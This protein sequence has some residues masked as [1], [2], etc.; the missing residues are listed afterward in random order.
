MHGWL[1]QP[2][3]STAGQAS[4][5]T[6]H[7]DLTALVARRNHDTGPYH[8]ACR[9]CPFGSPQFEAQ[10]LSGPPTVG[11]L[12]ALDADRV[13]LET[14]K[15]RVSLAVAD[16]LG[17]SAK[18]Q[19]SSP[20]P[21]QAWV[22]LVNGS[23]LWG[24]GVC[25]CQ[26]RARIEPTVG[27]AI[28]L[29]AAD[30]AVV[31]FQPAAA[32]VLDQWE[33]LLKIKAA[34]D[35]LVVAKQDLLDYHKGTI[36]DVTEKQIEFELEG[37]L[38]EVNRLKV[39]GLIYRAAERDLSEPVAWVA[40]AGGSR[41][42]VRS[43]AL[44][45]Q[46]EGRTVAGAIVRLPIEQ[47]VRIDLSQGKV[48]YLSDLKPE[49]FVY[50]PY[51]PLDRELP[52]RLEFFRIRADRTLE[53]KPLR[54]GGKQFSKG[55]AMHSRTEAVYYLPGRFRRF[56]GCGGHRRRFPSAGQRPA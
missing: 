4:S 17:V 5:D 53:S 48:V 46:F 27:E 32:A 55:L 24:Q 38:A 22:E 30:V 50:T 40:D 42:A 9:T 31:R 26:G 49:S 1:A 37:E 8:P 15:G 20:L 44:A 41:W 51:F 47:V 35:L 34:A 13:T 10:P 23:S 12:V 3:F 56:R 7:G 36:H 25:R 21:P 18:Q 2:C 16:L 43:M 19:P 54:L 29:P 33:R 39:F 28:D 14:A 11:S 52:A 45:R 6:Q